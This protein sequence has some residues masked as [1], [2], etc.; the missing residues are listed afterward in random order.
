MSKLREYLNLLPAALKHPKEVIDGWINV[1]KLETGNLPQ[2]EVEEIVRRRLICGQCP[3]M[4]ENAKKLVN[5][6]TSRKEQHCTLCSCPIAA[7]TS[8][9]DT[10]CGAQ[11]YNET[12]PDK[13]PLEVRWTIYEKDKQP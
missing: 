9:F 3:Y 11:Y 1:V 5:Y 8:S 2:D 10:V 13:P 7:K 6:K 12:H 4:S